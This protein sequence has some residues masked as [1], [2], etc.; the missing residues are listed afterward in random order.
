MLVARPPLLL[1]HGAI[2]AASTMRPLAARLDDRFT[3]HLLDFA[4]HA[5]SPA[6]SA[7]LSIELLAEQVAH[8]IADRGLAPARIFGF[9]LG[10]YVAL[11]LAATKPALVARVQ[12]LGTK[13]AWSP[14]VAV[15]LNAGLDPVMIRAKV[16]RLASALEAL[17][18]GMGWEPLLDA[19][20][21]MLADLGRHSRLTSARF[22]AI[23]HPVRL[24]VGDRDHTVSVEETL[25]AAR[26]LPAGELEVIPGLPHM[27]E[28]MDPDRIA[29]SVVEFFGSGG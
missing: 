14:D 11:Q 1:L 15:Q 18:T 25:A 21:A 2:G 4:G 8:F 7:P 6:P 17:H 5:A 10:G 26:A 29:R 22:A 9:S 27:L 24:T 3:I 16:P 12:T 20:R 19:T 23:P 28:K 13:L